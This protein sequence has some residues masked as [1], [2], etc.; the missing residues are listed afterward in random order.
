MS[1]SERSVAG[2]Q[3]T[4]LPTPRATPSDVPDAAAAGSPA[5][6]AAPP[7]SAGP[8][9]APRQWPGYALIGCGVALIPWLIVLATGLHPIERVPHWTTAWVGLDTM[10]SLGLMATGLLTVRRSPLR[11]AAAGAT[12]MLLVV[13][14][15]FDVTT[16]SGPDFRT[17]LLM[18]IAA[19]LPLAVVCATLAIR[20]FPAAARAGLLD[21]DRSPR[22]QP[23][24]GSGG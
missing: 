13:D 7:L 10:E 16:A 22:P 21:A 12:G 24:D 4:G 9:R 5:R 2:A 1:V 23:P 17:A 11:S 18:A 3:V 8:A 14:A 19:E 15:W 20:S 6:S